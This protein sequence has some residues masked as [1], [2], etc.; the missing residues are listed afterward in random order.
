MQIAHSNSSSPSPG[1]T[2]RV[3]ILVKAFL[4]ALKRRR[5]SLE[6]FCYQ[7]LTSQVTCLLH[8][9]N[10]NAEHSRRLARREKSPSV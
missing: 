4:A 8:G 9:H 2:G 10:G 3:G 7:V 6:T 5:W 1:L